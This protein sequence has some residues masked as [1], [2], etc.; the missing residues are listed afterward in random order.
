ME[1]LQTF[2]FVG[3]NSKRR[4]FQQERREKIAIAEVS[5]VTKFGV[6]RQ[7]S[8]QMTRELCRKNI[9]YVATQDLKIG[10]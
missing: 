8:K 4:D 9:F 7:T 6:S 5:V 3:N 2:C 1:Y 10:R